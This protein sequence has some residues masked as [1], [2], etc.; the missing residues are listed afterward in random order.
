MICTFVQSHLSLY[1]HFQQGK[2]DGY[3]DDLRPGA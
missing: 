2:L 1:E 3:E